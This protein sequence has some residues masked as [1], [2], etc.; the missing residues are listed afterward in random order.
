MTLDS[1]TI[2]RVSAAP[3]SRSSGNTAGICMQWPSHCGAQQTAY[4]CAT[5]DH[6]VT[7]KP[8]DLGV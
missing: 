8:L 5:L 6:A 7:G 2:W 4:V 3:N 1:V